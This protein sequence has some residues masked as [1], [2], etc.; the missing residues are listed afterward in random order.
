MPNIVAVNGLQY[1]DQKLIKIIIRRNLSYSRLPYSHLSYNNQSRLSQTGKCAEKARFNRI[2]LP[3]Q[4]S[5]LDL[6]IQSLP[7]Y[8]LQALGITNIQKRVVSRTGFEPA[9]P[10]RKSGILAIR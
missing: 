2:W 5:N 8:Q 7:C 4:G 10:D 6:E 3:S 1:H 9:L